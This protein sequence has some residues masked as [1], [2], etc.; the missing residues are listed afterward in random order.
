MDPNTSAV[1]SCIEGMIDQASARAVQDALAN[2][3]GDDT[4]RVC[5]LLFFF[6]VV[7]IHLQL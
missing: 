1:T 6:I 3:E 4:V 5:G 2:L 7:D